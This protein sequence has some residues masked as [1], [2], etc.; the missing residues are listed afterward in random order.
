VGDTFCIQWIANWLN[1][2]IVIWSLNN[3]ARYFLFNKDANA[4]P[5]CILFHDTSFDCGHYEP[6][7]YKKLPAMNIERY[8]DYLSHVC[9]DI[10]NY[11]K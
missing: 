7:I 2:S 5:Y 8:N 6:F 1:I 10:Q 11:W 3:N 9:K 4:N